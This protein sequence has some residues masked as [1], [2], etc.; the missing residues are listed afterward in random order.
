MFARLPRMIQREVFF[1]ETM[2]IWFEGARHDY[3]SDLEQELSRMRKEHGGR[4]PLRTIA[5]INTD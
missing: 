3:R 5:E 4:L 1:H 2:P